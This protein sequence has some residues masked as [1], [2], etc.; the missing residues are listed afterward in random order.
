MTNRARRAEPNQIVV[1][2]INAI[3]SPNVVHSLSPDVRANTTLGPGA[4]SQASFQDNINNLI[5]EAIQNGSVCLKSVPDQKRTKQAVVRALSYSTV[6]EP[7]MMQFRVNVVKDYVRNDF[8]PIHPDT[9]KPDTIYNSKVL[10]MQT[11]QIF[12]QCLDIHRGFNFWAYSSRGD[13]ISEYPMLV[14]FARRASCSRNVTLHKLPLDKFPGPGI[15]IN[16]L[17]G[18]CFPSW[19]MRS[20]WEKALQD[21]DTPSERVE[22]DF[23]NTMTHNVEDLKNTTFGFFRGVVIVKNPRRIKIDNKNYALIIFN[24]HFGNP[25]LTEAFLV[26]DEYIKG[27]LENPMEA[28]NSQQGTPCHPDQI[29]NRFKDR[30][31]NL[32][33]VSNIG[34]MNRAF[35]VGAKCYERSTFY[36]KNGTRVYRDLYAHE[37]DET[38]RSEDKDIVGHMHMTHMFGGWWNEQFPLQNLEPFRNAHFEVTSAAFNALALLRDFNEAFRLYSFGYDDYDS[39]SDNVRFS[40]YLRLHDQAINWKDSNKVQGDGG[41]VLIPKPRGKNTSFSRDL[42][43]EVGAIDVQLMAHFI[44]KTR[45]N[46]IFLPSCSLTSESPHYRRV[47]AKD[48]LKFHAAAYKNGADLVFMPMRNSRTSSK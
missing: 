23:R 39:P 42:I 30:V 47:E 36:N 25:N 6:P 40:E 28:I 26:P 19:F 43:R 24:D 29:V 14:R 3:T 12:K 48:W 10:Y 8:P 5:R 17:S 7:Q 37:R 41:L 32:T 9:D 31:L 45:G 44:H 2:L 15:V 38:L 20:Q 11:M 21:R 4:T 34:G 13:G 18:N 16:G 1:N 46:P 22:K 33:S 35:P 27:F